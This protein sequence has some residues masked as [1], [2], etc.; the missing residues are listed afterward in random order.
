M[1][2]PWKNKNQI[3]ISFLVVDASASIVITD[4]KLLFNKIERHGQLNK[5]SQL[6]SKY[7]RP[8]PP[9]LHVFELV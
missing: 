2:S 5:P 8:R 7:V 3:K 1:S 9:K 4:F 6:T